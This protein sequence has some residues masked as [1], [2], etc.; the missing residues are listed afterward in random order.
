M[1][2]SD[3][4]LMS[5]ER[6]LIEPAEHLAAEFQGFCDEFGGPQHIH[7]CGAMFTS[8]DFATAVQNCRD[9]ARGVNI[10]DGW[11]QCHVWW[12]MRDRQILGT[13]A[14]RRSLTPYLLERGGHIGYSIRPSQRRKGY[15]SW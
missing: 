13:I 11:V 1:P 9:H 14:L 4:Q 8:N 15:A 7:G 12:L 3:R 2:E 6:H 10:P 5:S